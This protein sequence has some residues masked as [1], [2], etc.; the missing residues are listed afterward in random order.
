MT[1]V[2]LMRECFLM[3][4]HQMM[5]MILNTVQPHAELTEEHWLVGV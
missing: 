3:E 1:C 4:L 2:Q 5:N